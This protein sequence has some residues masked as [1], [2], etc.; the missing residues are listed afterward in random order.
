[1][2]NYD[3]K[4]ITRLPKNIKDNISIEAYIGRNRLEQIRRV[5]RLPG[6]RSID[7]NLF[8]PIL[9][10]PHHFDLHA[11]PE[12]AWKIYDKKREAMANKALGTLRGV[13]DMEDE[14]DY[15]PVLDL[16]INLGLSPNTLQQMVSR[17]VAKGKKVNG[18][19]R[20]HNNFVDKILK[21]Y[22]DK[23]ASQHR[24]H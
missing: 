17:G 11:V 22:G 16:G 12:W 14:T 8:K 1:M 6:T 20:V 4:K 3:S 23:D 7:S 21:I 2:F 13:T 19:L 10:R 15:T 9:E 18:L 24:A 5:Y